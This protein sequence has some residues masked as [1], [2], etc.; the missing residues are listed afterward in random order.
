MNANA[1]NIL[2]YRAMV[3]LRV[4]AERIGGNGSAGKSKAK[5]NN[6]DFKNMF[7][8]INSFRFWVRCRA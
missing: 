3:A 6:S 1:I 8:Q 7:H 4:N 2:D 5:G